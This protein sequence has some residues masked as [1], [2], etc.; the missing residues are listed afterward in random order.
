MTERS[1][2]N[3]NILEKAQKLSLTGARLSALK[4]FESLGLPN[5]KLENYKYTNVDSFFPSELNLTPDAPRFIQADQSKLG[6]CFHNGY[7]NQ[8]SINLPDSIKLEVENNSIESDDSFDALENLNLA[9]SEQTVLI[10]INDNSSI[11]APLYINH[12]SSDN[13]KNT[14]VSTRVQIKVG[15]NSIVR[16]IE[17]FN[18]PSTEKLNRNHLSNIEV[19]ENANVEHVKV[20]T[21]GSESFHFGSLK[22]TVG[23]AACFHSFTF[24]TGAKLSRNNIQV[25]LN[26]IGARGEVHGLYALRGDQQCD[27]F[28]VINHLVE[29]TESEQLFKAVLDDLSHGIFTGKIV[30]HRDAQLVNSSQLNKNLLLSKKAHA[31]TR[32]QLEVY[33]DDVKCAHGATVGQLSE[34]ELFY[35]E[36]RA[37]SPKDARVMLCHGFV[38]EALDK[39]KSVEVRSFL[40]NLLFEEFEKDIH[41]RMR[42]E[43]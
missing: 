8:D 17:Q 25:D 18:S 30:V 42:E 24:T 41:T 28:S 12:F 35:L 34:E 22:A 1:I 20:V 32:P 23:K 3:K 27:N 38:Q 33:A 10:T 40:E 15:K 16:I 37:I 9:L 7:L 4:R 11:E 39:I 13:S 29:R 19:H 36:S 31:D 43:V 21:E 26:A 5:K 6:F 14:M 2:L